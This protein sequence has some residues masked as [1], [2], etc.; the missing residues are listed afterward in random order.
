[1]T[2]MTRITIGLYQFREVAPGVYR[3]VCTR[4]S[5]RG[6]MEE[7]RDV[8]EGRCFAC[9]TVGDKGISYTADECHE[10][11]RRLMASR[12]RYEAKKEAERLAYIAEHA[13]ELAAEAAAREAGEQAR[14]AELEL[15]QHVDAEMG[16]KVTVTGTVTNLLDVE[17]PFGYSLLI[18]IEDAERHVE[19]K[20]FTTAAWAYDAE[21]GQ[22]YVVAGF[23]KGFDV[24]EGR[25]STLLSRVKGIPA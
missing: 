9:D 7:H 5:G 2:T 22:Q 8:N 25:K 20:A 24:Y 14:L 18:V 10:R 11:A 13:D 16:E 23:V 19:V 12:D 17:T 1:M 21:V 3:E 15:W 4:C 6:W